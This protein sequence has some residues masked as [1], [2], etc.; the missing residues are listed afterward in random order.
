MS[1]R[2]SLAGWARVISRV[3][4]SIA[5]KPEIESALPSPNSLAPLNTELYGFGDGNCLSYWRS[6]A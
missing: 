2:K 4:S 6:T 5:F 1:D 3:V